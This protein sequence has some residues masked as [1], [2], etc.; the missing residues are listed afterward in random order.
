M[1][2]IITTLLYQSRWDS[3]LLT[4]K[5]ARAIWRYQCRQADLER[6]VR[7][8][9]RK[10]LSGPR[11]HYQ[12]LLIDTEQRLL[13][14]QLR[15]PHVAWWL[16]FFFDLTTLVFPVPRYC[17]KGLAAKYRL[18]RDSLIWGKDMMAL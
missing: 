11:A 4:W 5:D 7:W 14:H 6:L 2:R 3:H 9:T 18:R 17:R 12:V 8:A 10:R 1:T 13:Q 16:R 15:H